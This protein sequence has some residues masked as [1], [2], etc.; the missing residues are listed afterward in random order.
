MLLPVILL[1]SHNSHYLC[2][3]C[4]KCRSSRFYCCFNFSSFFPNL[5]VRS[6][7]AVRIVFPV[8]VYAL[9]SVTMVFSLLSFLLICGHWTLYLKCSIFK[10]DIWHTLCVN[11]HCAKSTFNRICCSGHFIFFLLLLC[12]YLNARYYTL[13]IYEHTEHKAHTLGS[14]TYINLSTCFCG[15]LY[16]LEL[17]LNKRSEKNKWIQTNGTHTNNNTTTITTSSIHN[18]NNSK[19]KKMKYCN[20]SKLY[21]WV[22]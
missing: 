1:I 3:L 10:C 6:L 9:Q 13:T 15:I 19:E 12:S 7:D 8:R 20:V 2:P 11:I 22:W 16:M 5:T 4:A 18:N 14:W 17:T 21:N